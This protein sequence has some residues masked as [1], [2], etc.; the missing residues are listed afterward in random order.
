[1]IAKTM[2]VAST[3]VLGATSATLAQSREYYRVPYGSAQSFRGYYGTPYGPGPDYGYG[4]GDQYGYGPGYSYGKQA[5]DPD[6]GF[7]SR[8]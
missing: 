8:Y 2:L 7:E 3:L 1:M 5:P 6:Y 4:G